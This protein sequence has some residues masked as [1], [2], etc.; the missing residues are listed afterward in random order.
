MMLTP[1]QWQKARK[2]KKHANRAAVYALVGACSW[3]KDAILHEL[4]GGA[5]WVRVRQSDEASLRNELFTDREDA[6]FLLIETAATKHELLQSYIARP[7]RGLCLAL[8]YPDERIPP[9]GELI[10][11]I[12]T[13]GWAIICR[14]LRRAGIATWA[15]ATLQEHH[16]I[17]ADRRGLQVLID[18]CGFNRRAVENEL[19]KLVLYMRAEGRE[20][21][22]FRDVERCIFN[23]S[24]DTILDFLVAVSARNRVGALIMLKRL[25]ESS[26]GQGL[27]SA[28]VR[29]LRQIQIVHGMLSERPTVADIAERLRVGFYYV[30]AL[31]AAARNFKRA[32]IAALMEALVDVG[33]GR[34]AEDARFRMEQ[35]IL[36][37]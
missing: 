16:L 4:A 19:N 36:R 10:E 26:G 35:V 25:W 18:R 14:P 17:V 24:S 33:R 28:M 32:E 22:T 34:F 31:L 12:E 20:L 27:L 11:A 37:L 13:K 29:R 7:R 30:P 9:G 3:A 2:A 8:R 21:V 15:E 6:D 23:Y 5:Q 1:A